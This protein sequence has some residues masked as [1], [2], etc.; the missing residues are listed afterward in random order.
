ML[1]Y[2]SLAGGWFGPFRVFES[3]TARAT[4]AVVLAFSVSV[5]LG[6]GFIRR[7]AA[8]RAVEDVAKPDARRL[9]ELHGGKRGTPTMGGLFLVASISLTVFLCCDPFNPLVWTGQL[10]L[11]G[12]GALGLV[13]DYWKLRGWGRQ[14]LAKGQKF[15]GEVVLAA[16]VVLALALGSGQGW[17]GM[18]GVPASDREEDIEAAANSRNLVA[19]TRL[20]IPFTKWSEVNPDLGGAYW[21][22]A[23]LII[24]ACSNAVN[25]TDGLDGL[26]TGCTA[27]VAM[28]YGI[29]AYIAGNAMT[30]AFF[31]IPLVP[32][33]GELSIFGA[34]L[35]GGL[36]GFLWF[37]ANPARVFMGDTGSLAL[38]AALAYLAIATKHELTLILAGGIFVFEALSV[39]LQVGGFR[40]FRKRPFKIAPFHHHLE[41]SGWKENH[42]VVRLWIVGVILSIMSLGLLKMH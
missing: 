14:G 18:S 27:M 5:L 1:R 34:A 2:L 41:Y 42:V 10:T 20:V 37:N 4:I 25:L 38:G 36:M 23:L 15:A 26:A 11:V 31:R 16:L 29:L 32:G 19:P 21:L 6:P 30:C 24:V 9:H 3:I 28:A 22:F 13:D 39:I 8:R 17:F 35:C 7:M 12:F 33:A 40:L